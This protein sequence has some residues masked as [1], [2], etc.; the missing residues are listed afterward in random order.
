[1]GRDIKQSNINSIKINSN[2][3]T[4]SNP[5]E[6]SETF[7]KFFIEIGESLAEK[8][9]DS[10]KSYREYLVQAQSS[11]QLRLVT[12]IEALDLLKKTICEQSD[13]P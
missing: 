13:R 3:C 8:L 2:S 5:Q 10:S 11:F 9:P 4:T 7:N 6:M 12:P 1:M